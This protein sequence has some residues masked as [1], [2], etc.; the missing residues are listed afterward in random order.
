MKILIIILV[1]VM[2]GCSGFPIPG[3]TA[4]APITNVGDEAQTI[5]NIDNAPSMFWWLLMIVGW[6]APSP[7][8]IFKGLA[9]F[10]LKLLGRK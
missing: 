1:L 3:I 10:I 9:D 5:N 6:I 2:A 4:V 7:Q 8:E